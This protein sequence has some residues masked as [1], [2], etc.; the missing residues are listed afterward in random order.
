MHSTKYFTLLAL[1]GTA[2]VTGKHTKNIM[3]QIKSN[4]D[5]EK[6]ATGAPSYQPASHNDELSESTV[7]TY[8]SPP[9]ITQTGYAE[10]P[11]TIS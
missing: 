4:M 11:P 8:L 5:Q 7:T 6:C 10:A 3:A 9:T 1:L 2:A